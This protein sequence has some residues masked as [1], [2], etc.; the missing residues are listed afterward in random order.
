MYWQYF[1]VSVS[2]TNR[3]AGIMDPQHGTSELSKKAQSQNLKLSKSWR[4][5]DMSVIEVM[6]NAGLSICERSVCKIDTAHEG[7]AAQAQATQER[8]IQEQATA[9][10]QEQ[11]ARDARTKQNL[12][13]NSPIARAGNSLMI[14]RPLFYDER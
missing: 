1:M 9:A 5:Q 8:A 11:T 3:F 4:Q 7:Q 2:I 14:P 12:V 6:P 10:T 13:E